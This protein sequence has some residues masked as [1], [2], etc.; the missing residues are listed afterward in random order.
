MTKPFHI[1][2][3]KKEYSAIIFIN[4]L[5]YI[6]RSAALVT[7]HTDSYGPRWT[8]NLTW[9]MYIRHIS[10][11]YPANIYPFLLDGSSNNAINYFFLSTQTKIL[12]FPN[13]KNRLRNLLCYHIDEKYMQFHNASIFFCYST[14]TNNF[15]NFLWHC[16]LRHRID[17]LRI[18]LKI[19]NH[20]PKN[21]WIKQISE[22]PKSN[23]E[24]ICHVELLSDIF[25]SIDIDNPSQV[26]FRFYNHYCILKKPMK[27]DFTLLYY[28][29]LHMKSEGASS[30]L[31]LS[32]QALLFWLYFSYWLLNWRISYFALL[33][34]AQL[35]VRIAP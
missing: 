35:W 18:Y 13:L 11:T 24:N 6:C 4:R 30:R 21:A 33:H 27:W 14:I 8:L 5:H 31:R 20:L 32:I 29:W 17:F 25:L 2:K 3:Y 7:T 22:V 1:S 28:L 16:E 15:T 34:S 23:S 19:L 12:C 9:L 10:L 26:S